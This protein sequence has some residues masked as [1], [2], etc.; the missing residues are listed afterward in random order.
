MMT[1]IMCPFQK[2]NNLIVDLQIHEV[3]TYPCTIVATKNKMHKEE[4]FLLPDSLV[5]PGEFVIQ[6]C[7]FRAGQTIETQ[8]KFMRAGP[9]STQYFDPADVRADIVCSGKATPGINNI[10]RE[11]TVML[12]DIYNVQSVTG[13]R[14]SWRGYYH[15]DMMDL[16]PQMVKTI[17]HKGGSFLGLSSTACDVI[18]IVDSL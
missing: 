8:K 11:L 16:T 5:R 7:C 4:P 9:R 15:N 2:V 10:I 3:R 17:H 12:K 1:K 18:K 14:F 13:I 6:N